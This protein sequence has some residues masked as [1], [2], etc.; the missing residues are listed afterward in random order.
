VAAVLQT[1]E[2]PTGEVMA[3]RNSIPCSSLRLRRYFLASEEEAPVSSPTEAGGEMEALAFG[4]AL[5]QRH[6]L[7]F[8]AVFRYSPTKAIAWGTNLT[9]TRSVHSGSAYV[10][11]RRCFCRDG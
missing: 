1:E 2:L 4:D 11:R 3:P 7:R 10:V 5:R 9:D 8:Q 6:P